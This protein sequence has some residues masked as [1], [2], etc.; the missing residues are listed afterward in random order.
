MG[1]ETPHSRDQGRSPGG[2]VGGR[3]PASRAQGLQAPVGV[4]GAKPPENFGVFEDNFG[5]L[6]QFQTLNIT[7]QILLSN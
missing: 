7:Y 4:K 6:G 1:G 2:G 5:N 3:A